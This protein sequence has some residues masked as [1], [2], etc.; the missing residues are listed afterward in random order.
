VYIVGECRGPGWD[1]VGGPVRGEWG[2]WAYW[3]VMGPASPPDSFLS[4]LHPVLSPFLPL[5]LLLRCSRARWE[6]AS[7]SRRGCAR[8]VEVVV[9][10]VK[11]GS[12][13]VEYQSALEK[14][15]RDLSEVGKEVWRWV[16]STRG[17]GFW[18]PGRN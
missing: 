8:L 6:V 3:L 1:P 9:V 12:E 18:H 4:P 16:V 11:V 5:Y 15:S 14:S 2:G 17:V 13:V 10:V 7:A